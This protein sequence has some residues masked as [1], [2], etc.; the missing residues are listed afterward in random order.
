MT[1]EVWQGVLHV[2]I[3]TKLME[4]EAG[5]IDG[6][7]DKYNG[8]EPDGKEIQKGTESRGIFSVNLSGC[9]WKETVKKQ[10]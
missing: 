7:Q 3:R 9:L 5:E 10:E 8:L 6:G 2:Q 1:S 4:T